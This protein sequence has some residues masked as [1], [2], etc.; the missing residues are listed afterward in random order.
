M[1]KAKKII[2]YGGAFN[3]PTKAHHAILQAIVDEAKKNDNQVWL[4]PSGDRPDKSI[5]I[6]VNMRLKLCEALMK[7]IDNQG[8]NLELVDYELRTNI[9]TN[10]LESSLYFEKK[11]PNCTFIWVFGSDSIKTMRTWPGGEQL[12]SSLHMLVIPRPDF[13]VTS[14][15]PKAKILT[16]NA[17]PTSSTEVR[18]KL[19]NGHSVDHLTPEHV[20][21]LLGSSSL[22]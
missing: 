2:V 14:L 22:Y 15:P 7:S 5:G 17:L 3:P 20:A 19:K 6:D 1:K 11:Y 13:D 12:F 18:E 8:V 4:V 9:E 10:T 21:R 16:V